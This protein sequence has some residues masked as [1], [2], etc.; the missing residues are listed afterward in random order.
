MK[1]A[2]IINSNNITS[3]I[4]AIDTN[5]FTTLTPTQLQLLLNNS[6][7]IKSSI[8]FH[9]GLTSVRNIKT[10]AFDITVGSKHYAVTA[11]LN[12]NKQVQLAEVFAWEL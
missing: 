11:L 1:S 12:K 2:K 6:S 7:S 3:I 10:D 5:I 9:K 8:S 4:K